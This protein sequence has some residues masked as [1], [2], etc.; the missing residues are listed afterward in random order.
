MIARASASAKSPHSFFFIL[1]I[2]TSRCF[3]HCGGKAAL[4]YHLRM[5]CCC[6]CCHQHIIFSVSTQNP[7]RLLFLH[8]FLSHI[9][10]FVVIIYVCPIPPNKHQKH[11]IYERCAY[12]RACMIEG[13]WEKESRESKQNKQPTTKKNVSNS[14]SIKYPINEWNEEKNI[15]MEPK[16]LLA[17]H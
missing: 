9:T 8:K 15:T 4:A 14:I 2:H 13:E 16:E 17:E 6:C 3:G 10:V 11:A 5:N 12:I 7:K 1:Y